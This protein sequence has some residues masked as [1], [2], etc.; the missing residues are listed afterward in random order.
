MNK[1]LVGLSIVLSLAGIAC[2]GRLDEQSHPCPCSSQWMCCT[3][4][5]VC[6]PAG[7]ACPAG[8]SGPTVDSGTD[9]SNVDVS[10][11]AND[12]PNLDVIQSVPDGDAQLLDAP[13]GIPN[14]AQLL[15][16][17]YILTIDSGVGGLC[18]VT[19]TAPATGVE[20]GSVDM[21]AEAGPMVDAATSCP[22]TRRP[23]AGNSLQCPA[24]IG[25]YSEGNLDAGGGSIE[26]WGR[27]FAASG[28]TAKLDFPPT[29]LATATDLK[30]IETNIPP[31]HDLLDWSPVYLVEPAGLS[32][33]VATPIQLPWSSGP[34]PSSQNR[35]SATAMADLSIW[36][37]ADGNCF[38]RIS[39]SYTNAGFE[40]GSVT[41]LGYFIVGAPRTAATASCP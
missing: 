40:Q 4:A 14:D 26:L 24:G 31:P 7:T 15:D 5:N 22:C 6:V 8:G 1:H 2:T 32:L 34:A 16:D 27:Q 28:V 23:G 21:D 37:S 10:T 38:T 41:R 17:K 18:S 39:D 19:D 9:A 11:S 3:G 12:A 36:F 25:E 13:Q 30:L 29:A 20:A 35:T 33:S